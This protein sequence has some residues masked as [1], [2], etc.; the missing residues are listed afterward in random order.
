MGWLGLEKLTSG[1][2]GGVLVYLSYNFFRQ[3]SP[4]D[5]AVQGLEKN[6]SLPGLL[7]KKIRGKGLGVVTTSP[8]MKGV[9]VTDY[10][11]GKIYQTKREKLEAERDYEFNG[12]GCYILEVYVHGKKIYLDATRRINT[13][14]RLV[15]VS[16][17]A[18]VTMFVVFAL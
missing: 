12:E 10:K 9:Y 18:V 16:F 7:V 14:G 8:I 13:I 15:Y 1:W 6:V 11:Y 5:I 17:T 4:R 2:L 3:A